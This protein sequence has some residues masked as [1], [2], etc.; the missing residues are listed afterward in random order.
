M[1][2]ILVIFHVL[3]AA[4]LRTTALW[5]VTPCSLVETDRWREYAPLKR[6]YTIR[7]LHGALPQKAFIFEL[8]CVIIFLIEVSC[9]DFRVILSRVSTNVH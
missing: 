8:V 1:E 9:V 3:T 5:D 2:C 4:S 6:P 7:R